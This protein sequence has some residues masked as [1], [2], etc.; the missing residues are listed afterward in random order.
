MLMC[1]TVLI[2][3]GRGWSPDGSD[4]LPDQT[5]EDP[6]ACWPHKDPVWTVPQKLLRRGARAGQDDYRRS[7]RKPYLF[8]DK[9]L[10]FFMLNYLIKISLFNLF[11]YFILNKYRSECVQA[12]TGRHYGER[13]RLSQTH[14]DMG[15]VWSV[16]EDPERPEEVSVSLCVHVWK[17]LCSEQSFLFI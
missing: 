5:K 4:R 7:V 1:L 13:E 15:A 10:V 8:Y 11:I 9:R 12:G 3:G 17:S 2:R 14:Q 16:D 6:G